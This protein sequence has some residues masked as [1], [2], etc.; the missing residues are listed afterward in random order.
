MLTITRSQLTKLLLVSNCKDWATA[1]HELLNSTDQNLIPVSQEYI[2]RLETESTWG[3][4]YAVLELN[5]DLGIV[6]PKEAYDFVS[7]LFTNCERK[8]N[9]W[10][11]SEGY[12]YFYLDE[13][14]KR[15]W[16]SYYRVYQILNK[17]YSV[18]KLQM[19]KIMKDILFNNLNL[20]GYKA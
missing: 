10:Y 3:E 16:F 11:N 12:L 20:T 7:D 15:L 13:N 5:L 19:S 18:N 6:Y 14:D 9:A 2:D 8:G 17:K 4:L 1:L